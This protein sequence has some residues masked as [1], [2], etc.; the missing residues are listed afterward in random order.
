M[1]EPFKN[2]LNPAA[3]G[4]LASALEG[5]RPGWPAA[6]FC[7]DATAGLEALELK[8]RVRHVAAALAVHLDEDF[9]AGDVLV[10]PATD[11]SWATLFLI[12]GAVVIDT[13]SNFSHAAIVAREMGIPAVVAA[14]GA[15]RRLASGARVRVDGQAGRVE[16]L[17][18]AD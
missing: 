3:V 13:G 11:P 7:A 12:A 8:D 16:V 9:A 5:A 2:L 14:E 10:A 4:R 15:S 18:A 6:A 1:A 17:A